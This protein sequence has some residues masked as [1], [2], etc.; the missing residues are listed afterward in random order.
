MEIVEFDHMTTGRRGELEGDE[1]DPFD[2]HGMTLRFQPKEHH[3]A[4]QDERGRLI[5]SAGVLVVKVEVAG[6]LFP[7]VGL[8]GVIVNAA[9]RGRGLGR[10]VANAAIA[11]AATLGPKFVILFC[12]EDRTGL[13]ARLGFER[14]ESPVLVEQP[15]GYVE[16]PMRTM[17]RALTEDATWPEGRLTVRGLPF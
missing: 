15:D 3:V 1:A 11:K 17:W 7:V 10:T 16:M 14:V 6:E 8:G 9:H 2:E 12:H 4:V 13:Y 5:A